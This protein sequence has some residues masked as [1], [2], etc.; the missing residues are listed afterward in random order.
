MSLLA[1]EQLSTPFPSATTEKSWAALVFATARSATGEPILF[2]LLLWIVRYFACLIQ[3]CST[4][5]T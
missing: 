4:L 5:R 1:Y 2:A 3:A